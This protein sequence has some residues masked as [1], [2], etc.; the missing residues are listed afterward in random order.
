MPNQ[1]TQTYQTPYV[2]PV[3]YVQSLGIISHNPS[4]STRVLSEPI[5]P[6]PSQESEPVEVAQV[7]GFTRSGRCYSSKEVKRKKERKDKEGNEA[8][9]CSQEAQ[10]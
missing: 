10:G 2:N 5:L 6:S 7:R 4:S 9:E 8:A 3:P 1:Q